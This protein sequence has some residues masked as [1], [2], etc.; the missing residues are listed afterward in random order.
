MVARLAV[1]FLAVDDLVIDDLID[2][3]EFLLDVDC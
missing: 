3:L 1:V 2:P